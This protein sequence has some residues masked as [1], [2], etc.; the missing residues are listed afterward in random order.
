MCVL[1]DSVCECHDAELGSERLAVDH[2]VEFDDRV[3]RSLG[4]KDLL[5]LDAEGSSHEREHE[6]RLV[7]DERLRQTKRLKEGAR[8]AAD[9]LIAD[10]VLSLELGER[11][12]RVILAGQRLDLSDRRKDHCTFSETWSLFAA[13]RTARRGARASIFLPSFNGLF[14]SAFCTTSAISAYLWPKKP[15]KSLEKRTLEKAL[16]K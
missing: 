5:G 12:H 16:P 4:V 7:G 14:V 10:A 3:R 9:L 2:F 11:R 1:P 13:L 8:S 15:L 6:H